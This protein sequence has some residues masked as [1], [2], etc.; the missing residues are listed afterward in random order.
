VEAQYEWPQRRFP[1]VDASEC[2]LTRLHGGSEIAPYFSRPAVSIIL[3]PRRAPVDTERTNVNPLERVYVLSDKPE[4]AWEDRPIVIERFYCVVPLVFGGLIA[5][6]R[7]FRLV[8]PL[9][10]SDFSGL[11]IEHGGRLWTTPNRPFGSVFC[12][13]VPTFVDDNARTYSH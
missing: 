7:D 4:G 12:F 10:Q 9:T 13:T 2:M 1:V 8:T 6:R 11:S 3:L 5:C